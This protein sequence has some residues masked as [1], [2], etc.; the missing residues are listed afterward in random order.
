[1][2]KVFVTWW[3]GLVLHYILFNNIYSYPSFQNKGIYSEVLLNNI[4]QYH[5]GINNIK[6]YLL[7]NIITNSLIN[8]IKYNQF[9]LLHE[10]TLA[11]NSLHCNR[12]IQ[13]YEFKNVDY[14]SKISISN[15]YLQTYYKANIH[16][17]HID[18][19]AITANCNISSADLINNNYIPEEKIQQY[20]YEHNNIFKTKEKRKGK[21]IILNDDIKVL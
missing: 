16:K 3:R 10:N 12:K 19:Q 17:F 13:Y 2:P 14:Q 21:I 1:M 8:S 20:Y 4:A 15:K 7:K 5:G 11:K 6:S 9:V 18:K